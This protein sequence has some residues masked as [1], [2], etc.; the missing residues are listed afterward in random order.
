VVEEGVAVVEEL[1][2]GD[3][4]ERGGFTRSVHTYLFEYKFC[5]LNQL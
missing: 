5:I 4:F 2:A 3:H 1:V